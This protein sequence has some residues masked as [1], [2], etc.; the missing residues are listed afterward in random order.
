VTDV[1][2]IGELFHRMN[3]TR[4]YPSRLMTADMVAVQDSLQ[5][6]VLNPLEPTAGFPRAGVYKG[7]KYYALQG[8]EGNL[9]NVRLSS[10]KRLC[11]WCGRKLVCSMTSVEFAETAGDSGAVAHGLSCCCTIED[12]AATV[13][14]AQDPRARTAREGR[15]AVIN[16]D[17]AQPAVLCR[18]PFSESCGV[19]LCACMS[20]LQE[21]GVLTS[22]SPRNSPH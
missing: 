18:K 4:E 19:V 5:P 22:A 12:S 11:V 20:Y 6:G 13:G 7:G 2:V 21:T 9:V 10:L 17:D 14:A 8:I 1:Q 16:R 15:G 3:C